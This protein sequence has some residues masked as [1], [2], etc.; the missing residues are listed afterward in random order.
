MFSSSATSRRLNVLV[1][2]LRHANGIQP[3]QLRAYVSDESVS[4]GG[5]TKIIKQEKYPEYVPRNYC[6]PTTA[7]YRF[8]RIK[9]SR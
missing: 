8:I 3:N 1:R 7:I 5:I 6:K 4:I 2:I 9:S